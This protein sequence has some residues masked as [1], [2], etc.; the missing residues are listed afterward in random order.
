MVSAERVT[1]FLSV[2]GLSGPV[3]S[4]TALGR[5]LIAALVDQGCRAGPASET[6]KGASEAQGPVC[7][8]SCGARRLTQTRRV[9]RGH[10]QWSSRCWIPCRRLSCCPPERPGLGVGHRARACLV[11]MMKRV[12]AWYSVACCGWLECSRGQGSSGMLPSC[13]HRECRAA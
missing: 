9:E 11:L 4:D 8:A 2:K 5:G 12:L 3:L 1:R 10:W 6:P 7:R 13:C